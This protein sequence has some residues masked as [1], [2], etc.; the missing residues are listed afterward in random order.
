[1]K[2][3]SE[4]LLGEVAQKFKVLSDPIRLRILH[5]LQAGERTVNELVAATRSSQP[6]I[7]K[8]LAL[9]K[10]AGLVHRRKQGNQAYFSIAAPY[11][12]E[13]CDIVCGGIAEELEK[14]NQSL[15]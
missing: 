2:Q 4:A 14:K 9:L 5:E 15:A 13:L 10:T 3:M 6:N 11:I 7:S 8:H 1:M 12:F